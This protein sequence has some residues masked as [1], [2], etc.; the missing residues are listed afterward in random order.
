MAF[1]TSKTTREKLP[2]RFLLFATNRARAAH[3]SKCATNLRVTWARHHALSIILR[4]L[5][6]IDG[7]RKLQ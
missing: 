4:F 7:E 3:E 2:R 1:H 6:G 5:R